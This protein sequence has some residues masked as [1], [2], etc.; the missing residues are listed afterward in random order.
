M[1]EDGRAMSCGFDE[2]RLIIAALLL[3][4]S[5][6]LIA[7]HSCP[8]FGIH[9]IETHETV[10]STRKIKNRLYEVKLYDNP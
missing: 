7:R 1:H 6:V 8:A 2:S 10:S 3:R 4:S 9:E 5:K